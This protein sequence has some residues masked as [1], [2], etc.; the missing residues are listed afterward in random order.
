MN[1]FAE[2]C[3]SI[4]VKLPKD[5]GEQVTLIAVKAAWNHQGCKIEEL[6]RKIDNLRSAIKVIMD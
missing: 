5:G 1:E 6:E 3:K 2:F 4:N